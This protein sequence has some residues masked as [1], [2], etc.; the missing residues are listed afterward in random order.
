M[1]AT[2][3]RGAAV[4]A[5]AAVLTWGQS[6][7]VTDFNIALLPDPGTEKAVIELSRQIAKT[8]PSKIVL[9]K[10]TTH[11]HITLYLAGFPA[12]TQEEV[13]RNLQE[14]G[15]RE[16]APAAAVHGGTITK[17]GLIMVGCEATD[18]LKQLHQEIVERLNPL[19]RGA[20]GHVWLNVIPTL[21]PSQSENLNAIGYPYGRDLWWP[22]FTVASISPD[23][24]LKV[25]PLVDRFNLQARFD[26]I[27]FGTSDDQGRFVKAISIVNLK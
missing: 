14:L 9:D 27:G 7:V 24:I 11:A 26:R 22:H 13:P 8:A 5:I 10:D 3:A 6:A 16:P 17:D 21:T 1:L 19:R 23:D 15:K 4:V 18:R 20:I 25:K 2:I 12:A